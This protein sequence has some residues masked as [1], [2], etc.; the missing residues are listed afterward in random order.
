MSKS[1]QFKDH[2]F[3]SSTSWCIVDQSRL[4]VKLYEMSMLLDDFSNNLWTYVGFVHFLLKFLSSSTFF[5]GD[6][7]CQCSV[8]KC[9]I[10]SRR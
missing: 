4:A 7:L 2:G 3:L 10:L 1:G 6:W 5:F 8:S 9:I